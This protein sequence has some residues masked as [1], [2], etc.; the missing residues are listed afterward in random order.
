MM[1]RQQG[2]DFAWQGAALA[3]QAGALGVAHL[4]GTADV[5]AGVTLCAV[6]DAKLPDSWRGG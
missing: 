6:S 1:R 4:V 2:S 5:V 3:L